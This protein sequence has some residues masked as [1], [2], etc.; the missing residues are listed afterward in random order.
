MLLTL[1]KKIALIVGTAVVPTLVVG[2]L[3]VA[4]S[5]MLNPLKADG[6]T[7]TLDSN[8][9]PEL[10][11]TGSGTVTDAKGVTWEYHNASD[12]ASGHVTLNADSYFGVSSS[13]S[14]GIT[15]ITSVVANFTGNELW[16]LTSLDGV[17]WH[18]GEL[19]T[20]GE[21]TDIANNWRYVRFYSFSS[22]I[23]INSVVIGYDCTGVSATED[24]DGAKYENVIETTNNLTYVADT[25]NISPNSIGGEAVT[26]TKSGNDSSTITIGFGRTYKISQIKDKTI[27]F[28]LKASRVDYGKT[29]Q[30]IGDTYT[31]STINSKDH[32]S[33]YNITNI[34]DD[35]YHVEV[36]VT[37]LFS[38]ISGY[39]TN[40]EHTKTKDEPARGI[41]DK[42]IKGIKINQGNCTIDNLRISAAPLEL[43]NYNSATYKPVVGE[44]YWLKTCWVGQI[45]PAEC[46]I[47]CSPNIGRHVGY[48]E[49][50]LINGSPLY[51]EWLASGT[52]TI[53]ANIVCGYNHRTYTITKTVTV[54]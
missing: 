11:N 50:V 37:C 6:P 44:I 1:G 22:T 9:Q 43:G 31:S 27:E 49:S 17:N 13:S 3:F 8:I 46:T 4:D 40:P 32:P 41:N 12:Y 21:P 14:Y 18:E 24:V 54:N 33:C 7:I 52:V 34:Q 45:Y 26:F 39:Y 38:T 2:T 35:W 25:T 29:V 10:D 20:T 48:T 51:I 53:T 47:T 5:Q 19:L 36:P 42:E 15:A 28:D 23:N 30:L 16:L